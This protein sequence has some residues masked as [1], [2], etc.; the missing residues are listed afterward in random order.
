MREIRLFAPA[1]LLGAGC[2]LLFG[3]HLQRIVSL[4]RPLRAMPLELAGY[5]GS[6]RQVSA[7]EQRVA[8]MTDYIF[9]TFSRDSTTAFSVYVGYYDSQTTG[10]TIHSPKNCLPGAGWEAIESG[11]TS[12]DIDGRAVTVNRYML[13]NGSSRALVYYWYQG[14]G[15][16]AYSEYRVKWDLLRDAMRFGRTEE[17]LVRI[18]V[19]IPAGRGSQDATLPQGVMD[20]EQ[21]A[22]TAALQL[23]P[24]VYDLLPTWQQGR[25]KA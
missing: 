15:R 24:R 4:D 20:A 6:D 10:R 12:L 17:A 1:A 18:V 23:V 21:V 11:N 25:P 7:D 3:S 13:A 14:R 9:R 2:F 8:G 19:P 16:V 5:D 22:S